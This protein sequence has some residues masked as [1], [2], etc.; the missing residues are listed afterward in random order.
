MKTLMLKP[1]SK[2]SQYQG[3]QHLSAIE[4]PIW[5]AL[6]AHKFESDIIID[7]EALNLDYNGTIKEVL[8]YDIDRIIILATGSHPSAHIQ[9]KHIMQ[10][11]ANRLEGYAEVKLFDH[12]PCS[13][14]KWKIPKWDLLPMDKYRAHNW[15]CWGHYS[16]QPYGVTYTSLGCPFNCEFCCV[17]SFYGTTF[18]QRLIEDVVEDIKL[19]VN[20]YNI[21]HIKFMDELFTLNPKRAEYIC[22][23]IIAEGFNDLNIWTYARID[24]VNPMLLEKFRK[25][26]IRWLA[27]GIES[28]NESIRKETSKG[29]FSNDKISDVI[30]MT[31]D[32]GI[33]VLGNFMFGFWHDTFISMKETLAFAKKL[34]CEYANFYCLVA[35]PGSKLYEKIKETNIRLPDNWEAYAQMSPKF[36]PLPT[37]FLSKREV[38][39]FRDFS[40]T[41]YFRNEKYIRMMRKTFG[42]DVVN[43]IKAMTSIKIKRELLGNQ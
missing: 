2:G 29:S 26:G 27:Y 19:L 39:K 28:G 12:L 37:K 13:P 41:N 32:A 34:Q 30:K 9:Q 6:M 33:Y 38:L 17:K 3:T 4:P 24:L 43:E 7:A 18:E 42:D 14:T 16:R 11:L 22:D 23:A 20:K 8:K 1:N 15:H 10:Q 25:A 21:K 31:K 36:E 40:F 35:Y 5:L